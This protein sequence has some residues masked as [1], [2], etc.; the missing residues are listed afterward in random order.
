M[1]A[2]TISIKHFATI[3]TFISV[4]FVFSQKVGVNNIQICSILGPKHKANTSLTSVKILK[5]YKGSTK[6]IRSKP[7]LCLGRVFHY[8]LGHFV[9]LSAWCKRTACLKLKLKT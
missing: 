8:K 7:N 3:C 1:K 4:I 6:T 9:D 2:A 5:L